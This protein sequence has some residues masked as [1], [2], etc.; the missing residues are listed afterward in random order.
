MEG[1]AFDGAVAIATLNWE[2]A[3]D[4][5]KTW[6]ARDRNSSVFYIMSAHS[7]RG[8]NCLDVS[9]FCRTGELLREWRWVLGST[10]D[11]LPDAQP[12]GQA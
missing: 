11:K 3:D 2:Q 7:E 10:F 5:P 8:T 12:E 4:D 1:L 9:A 6:T